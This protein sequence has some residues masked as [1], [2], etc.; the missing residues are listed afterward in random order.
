MGS[1]TG[2]LAPGAWMLAGGERRAEPVPVVTEPRSA[3]PHD[4]R[5]AP[6]PGDSHGSIEGTGPG[7]GGKLWDQWDLWVEA[8]QKHREPAARCGISPVWHRASGCVRDPLPCARPSWPAWLLP[9]PSAVGSRVCRHLVPDTAPL[10]AAAHVGQA[11]AHDSKRVAPASD[12]RPLTSGSV[13]LV[14]CL[15]LCRPVLRGP[16]PCCSR[17]TSRRLSPTTRGRGTS[18]QAPPACA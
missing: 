10:L 12:L 6:I 9:Q 2:A 8:P 14:L 16:R 13:E 3:R 17:H 11:C 1:A 7:A 15:C 4:E 5:G 18:R